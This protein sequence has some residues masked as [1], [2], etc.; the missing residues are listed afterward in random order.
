[1]GGEGSLGVLGFCGVGP[2]YGF[3]VESFRV[4]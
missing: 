2:F 4:Y 3:G 1:M